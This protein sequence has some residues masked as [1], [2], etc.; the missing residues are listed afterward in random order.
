MD[1]CEV[2]ARKKSVLY[3]ETMPRNRQMVEESLQGCKVVNNFN[4]FRD[5]SK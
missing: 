2:S 4:I 1:V 5:K 3:P